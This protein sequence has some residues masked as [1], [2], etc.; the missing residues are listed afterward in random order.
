MSMFKLLIVTPLMQG[1][2]Q[3]GGTLL[4]NLQVPNL[5]SF[6]G[7]ND[8]WKTLLALLS[9]KAKQMWLGG[10]RACFRI[11][12]M[13]LQNVS[14]VKMAPDAQ[15]GTGCPGTEIYYASHDENAWS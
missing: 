5:A 14:K 10:H 7:L 6:A 2:V 11:R 8:N 15:V 13:D 4:Y 1:G 9:D 12:H 3:Q